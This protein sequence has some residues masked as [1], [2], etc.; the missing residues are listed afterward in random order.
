M[1]ADLNTTILSLQLDQGVRIISVQ[2][3]RECG[4]F[5]DEG[6]LNP[7]HGTWSAQRYTYK[8]DPHIYEQLEAGSLVVVQ[9]RSHYQVARVAEMD[10][11]IDF[12]DTGL[13]SRLRW[14]VADVSSR[15][16]ILSDLDKREMAAKRQIVQARLRKE[17]QEIL[18]AAKL[19][20]SDIRMVGD[21]TAP[22]VTEPPIFEEPAPKKKKTRAARSPL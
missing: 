2:F 8:A 3:H 9:A 4:D 10:A 19:E 17:S 13:I 1:S 12:G 20:A 15:L 11:D 14:V 22:P 5:D 7:G 21:G 16:S 6:S 18:A